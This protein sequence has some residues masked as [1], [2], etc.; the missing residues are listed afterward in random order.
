M[1]GRL[2]CLLIEMGATP[3][4]SSCDIRLAAAELATSAKGV[5]EDA[6]GDSLGGLRIRISSIGIFSGIPL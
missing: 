6:R 5:V 2:G 1:D 4:S 3:I